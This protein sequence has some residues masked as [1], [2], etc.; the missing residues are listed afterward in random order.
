MTIYLRKTILNIKTNLL[1]KK[2][3]VQNCNL[4]T[5]KIGRKLIVSPGAFGYLYSMKNI[6]REAIIKNYG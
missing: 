1:Y 6:F 4:E 2:K 3:Y 5:I